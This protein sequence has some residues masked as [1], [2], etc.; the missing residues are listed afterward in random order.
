M[1][2][3]IEQ[4]RLTEIDALNGALL[5]EAKSLGIACPVNAAIVLTIKSL[6]VRAAFRRATPVLD[7]AALEAVARAERVAR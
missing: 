3:H 7:E 6:E 4:G 2:Q 1:L 5:A